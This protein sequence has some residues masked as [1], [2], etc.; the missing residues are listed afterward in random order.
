MGP[1]NVSG[2]A[3]GFCGNLRRQF[4]KEGVTA[5]DF[6]QQILKTVTGPDG[7]VCDVVKGR[8]VAKQKFPRQGV[9][10]HFSTQAQY[11]LI[12]ADFP[13]VGSSLT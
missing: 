8:T 4:L 2:F 9:S 11:E 3:S 10:E 7:L 13:Q 12:F 5:D 1:K 6:Q